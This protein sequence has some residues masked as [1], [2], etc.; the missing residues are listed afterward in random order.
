MRRRTGP[1]AFGEPDGLAL[2]G[3]QGPAMKGV[4]ERRVRTFHGAC[5]ERKRRLKSGPRA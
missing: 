4:K 3:F 5:V 1:L 2:R